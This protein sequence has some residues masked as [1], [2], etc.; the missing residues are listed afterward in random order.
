M[1]SRWHPHGVQRPPSGVQVACRL[2][3]DQMASRGA[4][5]VNVGAYRIGDGAA[6]K[7]RL[8]LVNLEKSCFSQNLVFVI[9]QVEIGEV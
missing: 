8:L 4:Q 5:V 6:P 2:G 3:P 7:S 9:I 1:T